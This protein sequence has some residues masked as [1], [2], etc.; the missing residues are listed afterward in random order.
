MA[1]TK[2]SYSMITGAPG[3]VLDYG[4][5]PTGTTSSVTAIVAAIAANQQLEFPPGTYLLDDEIAIDKSIQLICAPANEYGAGGTIFKVSHNDA[6]KSGFKVGYVDNTIRFE[7][8]GEPGFDAPNNTYAAYAGLRCKAA[9]VYI[10]G[11]RGTSNI[12]GL[13]ID[14][15]YIGYVKRIQ[16]TGK[17]YLC[18]VTGDTSLSFEECNI[19]SSTGG[20]ASF[21]IE[22]SGGYVRIQNIYLEA[23]SQRN[24]AITNCS[25]SAV[26]IN[27]IYA[28]NSANY[29]IVI[30]NS[31]N[32]VIENYR[33]NTNTK[34]IVITGSSNVKINN[35]H[36]ID[37]FSENEIVNIDSTS[38]N[39]FVGGVLYD[40]I[41]SDGIT[42]RKYSLIRG[43]LNGSPT[44]PMII[45][46]D[47]SLSARGTTSTV[48]GSAI[49]TTVPT[50][51]RMKFS[52]TSI[53]V[54][55]A[56]PLKIPFTKWAKNESVVIQMIYQ[57]TAVANNAIEIGIWKNG[58]TQILSEIT[59]F[60]QSS[61]D[62]Q[63]VTIVT[64]LPDT[65]SIDQYSSLEVRMTSGNTALVHYLNIS[66]YDGGML[67]FGFIDESVLFESNAVDLNTVNSRSVFVPLIG[68][69]QY[70][71]KQYELVYATNTSAGN[72]ATVA[73][74]DANSSGQLPAPYCNFTTAASSG[75]GLPCNILIAAV[76][77]PF[78]DHITNTLN[79]WAVEVTAA[80]T[81]GGTAKGYI[82]A[83]PM[84]ANAI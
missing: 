1:L 20:L 27:S 33:T 82:R 55:D 46:P 65:D 70:R 22:T 53:A 35:V 54:N 31:E 5:D 59:Y 79:G 16:G 36:A 71:F 12:N 18:K 30:S 17:S 21:Q 84:Q 26:Y 37:R 72:P 24:L 63:M 28:E 14:N 45:N 76:A 81:T 51:T 57:S 49:S 40:P 38:N 2:V 80:G 7:I 11:I 34:A 15:C 78:R 25:R 43:V 58:S 4:A 44:T 68:N 42:T 3:N 39:I 13:F 10:N 75:A 56:N 67:P 73:F 9:T 77:Y 29:D 52:D 74:G 32:I 61:A 19:G 69:Q 23:Q 66:Q 83:V 8:V 6:A 60:H 62:F 41:S 47:L 50:D 64:R 48:G